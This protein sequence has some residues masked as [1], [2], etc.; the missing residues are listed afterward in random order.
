MTQRTENRIWRGLFLAAIVGLGIAAGG[1]E[2]DP[3]LIWATGGQTSQRLVCLTEDGQV[4][5]WDSK[6]MTKLGGLKPLTE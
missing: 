2:R 1:A 6:T 4:Y 3:K 5:F